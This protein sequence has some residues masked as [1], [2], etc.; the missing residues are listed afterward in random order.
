MIPGI[1]IRKITCKAGKYLPMPFLIKITGQR[2]VLPFYHSVSDLP[3]PHLINVLKIRNIHTF[4]NDLEFLLTHFRPVGIQE[5]HEKILSGKPESQP[6][7]HLTFD[8][9]LKEMITTVAPLLKELGIPAT[10]FIN[11]G[12]IGNKEMFYR[13]K[14]SVLIENLKK[15]SDTILKTTQLLLDQQGI[16]KGALSYRL[17]KVNYKTKDVLNDIAALIDIDFREYAQMYDI[18]LHEEDIKTLL[19]QGFTI[20]AHSIDHP[21]FRLEEPEEQIMQTIESLEY[22]QDHFAVDIALF[23][24]PFSDEDV[25][26]G[27]FEKILKPE[28]KVDLSFGISGLKKDA[29][30]F[31]FHRI[32]METGPFSAGEIIGGEFLYFMMKAIAGKNKI[33]RK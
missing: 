19:K 13:Y 27:F 14:T 24:F 8:D 12:F 20:G 31:H 6:L 21:E 23:S 7:F 11:T 28:G 10:F 29:V 26:A 18:Y 9:G 3:L 16:D 5:L 25:S 2:L 32:P 4:R 22:L 33:N 1:N 17:L 30:P 15:S